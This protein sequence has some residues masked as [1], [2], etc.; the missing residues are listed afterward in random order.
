MYFILRRSKL[1]SRPIKIHI[2][3]SS[4]ETWRRNPSRYSLNCWQPAQLLRWATQFSACLYINHSHLLCP[5]FRIQK[6]KKKNDQRSIIK[7][8][9]ALS[10]VHTET[11]CPNKEKKKKKRLICSVFFLFVFFATMR[12]YNDTKDHVDIV[13][14]RVSGWRTNRLM[15]I[16]TFSYKFICSPLLK[17]AVPQNRSQFLAIWY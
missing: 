3:I 14:V 10:S 4:R 13:S 8:H 5:N 1:K 2:A 17:C 6:K 16:F 12:I 11:M 9:R 7:Y 15:P